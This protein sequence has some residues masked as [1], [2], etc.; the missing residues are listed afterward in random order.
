[1]R[2]LLLGCALFAATAQAAT[3]DEAH[4]LFAARRWEEAAAAYQSVVDREPGNA[5]AL[6]RL[7]R[8]SAQAG[9]A[10]RAIEALRAWFATG[11]GSYQVAMSLPEFKPLQSDARFTALVDPL[12][13]CQAPEFG[14]FDF[15]IGDWD[16]TSPA[17]PGGVSRNRISRINGGCTLREEYVTPMGYEGTS[18]NFYDAARKVWHQTWIDNQGQPLYIEGGFD[19][20]SMVLATTAD[21]QNV[22]RI[23]WTPLPDGRVRQHWESTTD[24]GKTWSTVFDG[25]YSR[26]PGG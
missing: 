5:L 10:T 11:S 21:P 26:R 20:T 12:R 25:Y 14:Q 1:M 15:W 23:T 8:S 22:Q 24:G 13:P 2:G 16:V 18:L 6:I 17:N 19:G 3:L 7:A 4:A 9:D